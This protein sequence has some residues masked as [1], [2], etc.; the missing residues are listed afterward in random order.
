MA[1]HEASFKVAVLAD[2]PLQRH[3]L[4]QALSSHGYHVVLAEDPHRLTKNARA[5]IQ[6]DLWVVDLQQ[7]ELDDGFDA[8][9]CSLQ[10]PVLLG[11]EQAP[12]RHSERY[13][14]WERA[15]VA[16]VAKLLGRPWQQLHE[17]DRSL[18]ALGSSSA[19]TSDVVDC[20]SVWLLA[21]GAGGLE[22]VQAFLAALPKGLPISFIY[23]QH[24]AEAA[25]Q[26]LLEQALEKTGWN[27]QPL[28]GSQP[29][30][31]GQVW[32]QPA[33]SRLMLTSDAISAQ[34]L[35]AQTLY[36][37][38]VD[39]A[40]L[41]LA[42]RWPEQSGMIVFSGWGTDGCATADYARRHGVALWTQRDDNTLHP[43][44]GDQLRDSGY[45]QRSGK[46]H[47]LAD[48]LVEWLA[49]RDAH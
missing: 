9:L 42:Q 46:P 27:I 17:Q 49:Q 32:L 37:P 35:E 29:W 43:E 33:Q 40:L 23:V 19:V 26:S 25:E 18:S 13:W 24:H 20:S 16:K 31:S 5:D 47:E 3:V 34:S 10:V 12:D 2:T 30:V 41:G 45:S 8:W 15:W 7:E 14:L 44:W 36:Q 48:A 28:A 11:Q 1:N 21:A 4:Q 39:N 38:S 6:A 22:P